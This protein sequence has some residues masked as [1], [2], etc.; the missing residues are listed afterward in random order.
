MNRSWTDQLKQSKEN[1]V[2]YWKARDTKQKGLIIGTF[3]FLF[4]A[5]STFIFLSS[6]PQYVPLYS[7]ELTQREAGDIKAELDKQGY[8]NYQLSDKG[9][10][11]LVPKKDA[12]DLVV[13]LASKGYPK[14]N[15]IN[16]DVF[17][18]NLSFGAS[19]RQ[20]NVLEREAMQNE[21]ADV[22]KRVQGIKNAQVILTIPKDSLFVRQ[23]QDKKATA[24]IMVEVEPGQKL[25]S[26]Q[27]RALYTLVSRSVPNLPMENITIMNQYS[28]TLSLQDAD[29][30]GTG[31][32]QYDKQR[33]I[34]QDV[35]KDVQE[36]LQRML[37]TIM[38]PDKVIVQTFVKLNFDKVKTEE[39][40][41]EPT[42]K[43]NNGIVVSAEKVSKTFHGKGSAPATV[44]TGQADIPQYP[45]GSGSNGDSDYEELQNRVNYEFN[46]IN[47]EIVKSPYALDDITINVGV[48]PPDPKDPKSLTDEVKTNI[49][50][51]VS[52][53]ARTALGHQNLTQQDIDQRIT[54]FPRNF[55]GKDNSL[56]KQKPTTNWMTIG[57]GAAAG[58]L[59]IGGVVWFIVRRR[60][61]A[62]QQATE[63]LV[64][65]LKKSIPEKDFPE[66]QEMS[67][68]GELKKLVK[69]RP[70][71]FAKVIKTWLHDEE[72]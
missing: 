4:V 39:K 1:T 53:V 6:R 28:E 33:K 62:E 55:D 35:E 56:Q 66:E 16:Y 13:S 72:V 29:S 8:K 65:P 15:R 24:S 49:K 34:R 30:D 38:G 9:T 17:S 14:D 11:V 21:L 42:D 51:I 37:G 69:Q 41:V 59:V 61:K 50:N 71:D 40:K 67:V 44:G 43:K 64:S 57:I 54:I 2:E 5:I 70:D 19:D 31:L 58:L 48:E 27:I 12:P 22:I 47:T 60:K 3:L 63:S 26:Q 32:D 10:M 52:N 36:N 45:G 7:G 18:Q 23:D 46:R 20:Y 68:E 25:D